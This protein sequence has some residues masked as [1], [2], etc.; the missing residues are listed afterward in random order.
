MVIADEIQ[1]YT[2]A[3]RDHGAQGVYDADLLRRMHHRHSA[4]LPVEIAILI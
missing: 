3:P 4:A 2:G 1:G